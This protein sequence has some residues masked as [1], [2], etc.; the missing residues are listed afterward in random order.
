[1]GVGLLGGVK[2]VVGR[3]GS[4]CAKQGMPTMTTYSDVRFQINGRVR[5][6]ECYCGVLAGG[7]QKRSS[8][9]WV[10]A[11]MERGSCRHVCRHHASTGNCNATK[12]EPINA[13]RYIVCHIPHAAVDGNP[14]AG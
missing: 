2:L 10:S 8:P 4:M 7:L 3:W 1:M 9:S 14:G 11:Q 5:V 6:K 12:L 13:P